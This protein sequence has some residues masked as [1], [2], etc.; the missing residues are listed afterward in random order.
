MKK[1]LLLVLSFSF[2]QSSWAQVSGNLNHQ[3]QI[4][5]SDHNID[6]PLPSGNEVIITVKGLANVKADTYVAIFSVMQQGKTAEEVNDLMDKRLTKSMEKIKSQSGVETYVD[7]ISFV[8]V[9][10]FEA[11]KKIFSKKTYN[12]IP[13][14]FELKKNIHI[15][16]S[17]PNQLNDFIAILSANEIYD[18]VKVDYFSNN[19]E[20]VKKE[21]MS[22][23][24]LL[25]QEKIKNYENILGEPFVNAS[26]NVAD[27]YKIMMP[28]EMY[29]SY[30]AYNNSE[31]HLR[32]MATVHQ[33]AKSSTLYYQPVVDKEF[34]F[35]IHPILLEPMIQVMYEL[36]VA[37]TRVEK[38]TVKQPKEYLLI[39]PTGEV[40]HLDLSG[41]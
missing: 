37:I 29:K 7:M 26:R 8:P 10:E 25:V 30:Q 41:Q 38:Q 31:L 2:C 17:D 9:Y 15:T 5:F 35:V 11:E 6:I 36:K 20:S 3:H 23:A 28:M 40:K 4:R 33:A 12:E 19:I 27:G 16:Y 22:K 39:T 32:K 13:T 24:K 14:G 34:D 18:L 1:L 21:L